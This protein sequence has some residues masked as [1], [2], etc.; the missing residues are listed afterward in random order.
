MREEGEERERAECYKIYNGN[1]FDL[2]ETLELKATLDIRTLPLV[3]L[4]H[5][6]IDWEI[7]NVKIF[8]PERQSNRN[9]CYIGE[10]LNEEIFVIRKLESNTNANY[11]TKKISRC[12]V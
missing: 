5:Y 8:S 7:V 4:Q 12:T 3:D 2:L 9:L 1:K 6:S 11:F 10:L